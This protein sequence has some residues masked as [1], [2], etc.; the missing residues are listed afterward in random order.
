MTSPPTG[1]QQQ[2]PVSSRKPRFKSR[3]LPT[4][5]RV[6]TTLLPEP[7]PERPLLTQRVTPLAGVAV[8]D[9]SPGPLLL[10]RNCVGSDKAR[11]GIHWQGRLTAGVS[12]CRQDFEGLPPG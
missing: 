3:P 8:A 6:G 4:T 10:Y 5:P 7:A 12:P 2:G 11:F 9:T 1:R